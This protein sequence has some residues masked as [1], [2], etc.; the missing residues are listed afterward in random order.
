MIA[1]NLKMEN[2]LFL[3]ENTLVFSFM[4]REKIIRERNMPKS[5]DITDIWHDSQNF[6]IRFS[7][8]IKYTGMSAKEKIEKYGNEKVNGDN[9]LSAALTI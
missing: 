4:K 1:E 7:L 8:H 9:Y 3:T 6:L 5:H 2:V